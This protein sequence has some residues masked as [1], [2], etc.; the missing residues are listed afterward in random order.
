MPL[1]HL[2]ESTLLLG[3]RPGP[4]A[5]ALLVDR[6]ERPRQTSFGG[7]LPHRRMAPPRLAPY[8]EKAENMFYKTCRRICVLRTYVVENAGEAP[9]EPGTSIERNIS[10]RCRVCHHIT[11]IL[12]TR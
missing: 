7:T 6:L 10:F 8:M 5:A 4:H 9:G 11:A 12:E 2:A 1:E 3:Q